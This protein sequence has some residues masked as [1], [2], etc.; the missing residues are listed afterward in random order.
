MI[1]AQI[2]HGLT[3]PLSLIED[4]LKAMIARRFGIAPDSILSVALGEQYGAGPMLYAATA[5]EDLEERVGA[6]N[7][8]S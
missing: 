6:Q 1:K 5:A 2:Q 7:D 8:C 3:I 4:D